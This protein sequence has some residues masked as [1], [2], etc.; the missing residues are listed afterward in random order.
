MV[1]TVSQNIY[2]IIYILP[3]LY[4]DYLLI[5]IF[6]NQISISCIICICDKKKNFSGHTLHH[7]LG[8]PKLI[9]ESWPPSH[10]LQSAQSPWRNITNAGRLHILATSTC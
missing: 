2:E 1:I 4:A 5:L 6:S 7:V 10:L 3:Y 8:Y 9:E